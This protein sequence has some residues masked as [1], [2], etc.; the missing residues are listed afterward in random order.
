MSLQGIED[1]LGEMDFKMAGTA[2]GLTALQADVKVPGLPMKVVAETI[3]KGFQAK[4]QILQTM[5]VESQKARS[6]KK[7]NLPVVEKFVVPAHKRSHFVG[8]SG[9]NLR[10]ITAETGVTL[11][12]LDETSFEVFAPN[13]VR[14]GVNSWSIM[15][16]TISSIHFQTVS[17]TAM[18]EAKE[19][20]NVLLSESREPT[21]EFGGVYTAKIVEVRETG[22]MII[23]Y[24]TM[25]PTLLH[26]T[27][28]DQRKVSSLLLTSPSLTVVPSGAVVAI[29]VDHVSNLC[30]SFVGESSIRSRLGGRS[31]YPGEV[32]RTRSRIR[33][34]A[35]LSESSASASVIDS[36]L[37]DAQS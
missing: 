1:Y 19:I 29:A 20:M 14:F 16:A 23:L 12:P 31:G 11:I 10:K 30:D 36:T 7:E 13:K 15:N 3:Q 22:V 4:S 17:Q 5:H 33:Q 21:L 9:K 8:V 34:N 28:L 32:L 18:V 26:N 2:G 25:T 24:P 37:P 27:Q 35:S 6:H